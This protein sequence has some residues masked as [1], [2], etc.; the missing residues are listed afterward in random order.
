[1]NEAAMKEQMLPINVG[2]ATASI[3]ILQE[4]AEKKEKVHRPFP[5]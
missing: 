1:M 2:I 3:T 4:C 5:G